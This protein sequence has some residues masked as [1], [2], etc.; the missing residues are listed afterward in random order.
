MVEWRNRLRK[1]ELPAALLLLSALWSAHALRPLLLPDAWM[2]ESAARLT[3]PLAALIFVGCAA[4][5]SVRRRAGI[6]STGKLAQWLLAG[7]GF[8]LL[9]ALLTTVAD[10]QRFAL[11]ALVPWLT[12]VLQPYWSGREHGTKDDLLPAL[13][14]LVGMLLL[15][16]FAL[17]RG[18]AEWRGALMGGIAIAGLTIAGLAVAGCFVAREQRGHPRALVLQRMPQQMAVATL[19]ALW[20]LALPQSVH[21]LAGLSAQ[22][23]AVLA[24]WTLGVELPALALLWW[25]LARMRATQAALRFVLA[26]V[27]AALAARA[28]TGASA[29]LAEWAGAA[30]V[31]AGAAWM[32]LPAPK[33]DATTSL[34]T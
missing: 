12:A 31:M 10:T 5:V 32:L 19:P 8:F 11:M 20:P 14:C 21:A 17:P 9:S 2:P 34:F 16:P 28:M 23:T 25:L 22:Q 24:L 33:T 7:C 15:F 29:N 6:V 18:A 1:L 4:A 26:P 3:A 27:L 13:L 30:A